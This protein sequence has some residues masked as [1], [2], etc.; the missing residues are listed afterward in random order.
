MAR[1]LISMMRS[2]FDSTFGCRNICT[3]TVSI[4]HILSAPDVRYQPIA[5]MT[6]DNWVPLPTRLA[7]KPIITDSECTGK[8]CIVLL[9]WPCLAKCREAPTQVEIMAK[10]LWPTRPVMDISLIMSESDNLPLVFN[11][12]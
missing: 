5:I 7:G 8:Y 11:G 1:V 4:S 6:A 12:Q 9:S 10:R 3:N 2:P